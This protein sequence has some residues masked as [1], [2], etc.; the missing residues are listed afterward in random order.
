MFGDGSQTRSFCYVSDLIEGF[1]RLMGSADDFV[2]PVNLGN[3]QEFTILELAQKVIDL[4][5]SR[6]QITRL[7]LPTDDPKQR[8]PDIAL[9]R[10][11]LGWEPAI[12]L[13]DGLPPTI[14]YFDQL[15]SA[16]GHR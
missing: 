14:A 1:Y 8:K 5:G 13:S 6:S 3:P 4:T 10:D 9:A 11:R 15:L 7:P 16:P 12:P 2:G